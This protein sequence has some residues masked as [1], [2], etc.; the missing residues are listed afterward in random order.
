MGLPSVVAFE[1]Y[2]GAYKSSKVNENLRLLQ[3]MPF[4]VLELD[5]EDARE[6]GEIRSRL[7]AVGLPIGPYDLLIAGQAKRRN[8][9]LITANYREF[10]RVQGLSWQDWTGN[11]QSAPDSL[12]PPTQTQ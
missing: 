10:A 11:S 8:L 7:E 3:R 12:K 6:A 5:R 1:L 2:Y 4:E 9:T